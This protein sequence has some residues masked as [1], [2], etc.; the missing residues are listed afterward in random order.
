MRHK[1]GPFVFFLLIACFG[2]GSP[3]LWQ[4]TGNSSASAKPDRLTLDDAAMCE[5]T[6]GSGPQNRAVVF[7]VD[8][9]R[10]Y[11]FTSFDPVPE[12]TSIHHNWFHRHNSSTKI[13]LTLKPPRWS[14]VS[15]IQLRDEDK[16]PWRVEVT[17][18]KG[19][20]LYLLRFSI[21]D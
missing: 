12:A 19:N 17:D 8:R 3:A 6:D 11:C 20:L 18:E 14:T 21:T 9:G 10:V 4:D 2:S 5:G 1:T 15:G 7:S 16:G 13:K